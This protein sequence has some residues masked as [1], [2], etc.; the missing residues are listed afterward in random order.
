MDAKKGRTADSTRSACMMHRTLRVVRVR[1]CRS[2]KAKGSFAKR[3][4]GSMLREEPDADQVERD[5]GGKR[6]TSARLRGK[7]PL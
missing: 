7:R 6:G 4:D 3:K 5:F 1:T 2:G